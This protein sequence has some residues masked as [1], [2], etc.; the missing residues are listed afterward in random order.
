[1]SN[2]D[3]T[4]SEC[5]KWLEE[6]E[7]PG[8][9]LEVLRSLHPGSLSKNVGRVRMEWIQTYGPSHN[10]GAV[11]S[12]LR[13]VL[14]V[15]KRE[16]SVAKRTRGQ[17]KYFKQL[18]RAGDRV[19][20]FSKLDLPGKWSAR[21]AIHSRKESFAGL[22]EIDELLRRVHLLP[23]YV[24]RLELTREEKSLP[25][26]KRRE[27]LEA[28]CEH[29]FTVKASGLIDTMESIIRYPRANYFELAC[30]LSFVSGRGVPELLGSAQFLPCEESKRVACV[31][32]SIAARIPILC[33]YGDFIEGIERLRGMKDTSRLT[34]A[35]INQRYSKS[36]NVSARKLL[37]NGG[38]RHT[39]S[40]FKVM[41]AAI[42]YELFQGHG[43]DFEGW[44]KVACGQCSPALQRKSSTVTVEGF[45]DRHY[46][47]WVVACVSDV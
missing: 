6:H 33:E 40:D 19:V 15:I 4:V 23:P 27:A 26:I 20:A 31:H 44:V 9:V 28:K 21:N 16:A 2:I 25:R 30:A 7:N 14:K 12:D 42:S 8:E 32:S 38:D 34:A 43:L 35:E 1:M 45:E 17:N 10:N 3:Q 37:V 47:Q 46:R 11:R 36:A 13:R 5:A 39:F 22:V 24:S 29:G 41:H 18:K